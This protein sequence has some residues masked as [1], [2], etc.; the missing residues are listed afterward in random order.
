MSSIANRLR[1]FRVAV[2]LTQREVAHL[3]DLGKRTIIY[4]EMGDREIK[5]SKLIPLAA[6][7]DLDFNWL[8]LGQGS[9]FNVP[10]APAADDFEEDYDFSSDTLATIEST[11]AESQTQE[12]EL[13]PEDDFDQPLAAQS[14]DEDDSLEPAKPDQE[15]VLTLIQR[16]RRK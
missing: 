1:E 14:F 15:D 11:L 12:T 3:C 5:C 13:E 4:W 16:L 6:E 8:I 7:Y 9:M 2:G 10:P